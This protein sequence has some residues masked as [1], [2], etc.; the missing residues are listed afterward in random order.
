[1]GFGLVGLRVKGAGESFII[2]RNWLTL[3]RSSVSPHRQVPKKSKHHR[4][5]K[6]KNIT[7]VLPT[8]ESEPGV[9]RMAAGRTK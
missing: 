9:W 7:N 8:P 4:I 3:K 2:V 6:I 5:Q 1:M